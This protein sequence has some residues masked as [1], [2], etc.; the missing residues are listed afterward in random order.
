M[1]SHIAALVAAGALAALGAAT[2]PSGAAAWER[3]PPG[4]QQHEYCEPLHHRHHHHHHGWGWAWGW[5][6]SLEAYHVA[7]GK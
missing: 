2:L 4:S 6:Y 3:C 1:K 7:G 5:G